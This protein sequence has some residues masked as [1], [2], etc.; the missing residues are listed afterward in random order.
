VVIED[1]DRRTNGEGYDIPSL[2]G[3]NSSGPRARVAVAVAA[4]VAPAEA[5]SDDDDDKNSN[6]NA[7][8]VNL[9]TR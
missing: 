9:P 4:D 7:I 3:N 2:F 6:S 5:D 1:P 8:D